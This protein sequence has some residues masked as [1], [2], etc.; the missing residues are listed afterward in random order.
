M[1]PNRY[2]YLY[3][4]FTV[5]F[6]VGTFFC[7]NPVL[8][9]ENT[10]PYTKIYQTTEN[11]FDVTIF[12]NEN[13]QHQPQN[14]GENFTPPEFT[15]KVYVAQNQARQGMSILVLEDVPDAFMPYDQAL[16]NLGHSRTLVTD[17]TAF[18]AELVGSPWD[19]V[20]VDSYN[21]GATTTVLDEL[22]YHASSGGFL[23]FSHWD[24][25]NYQTHP[26]LTTLGIGYISEF[27]VPMSFYG[28]DPSHP[29]FT[30]P[31]VISDFMWTHDQNDIDGQ[32]VDVL[33][34]ALHLAHFDGNPVSG[35]LVQNDLGN[36]F[37]N[38][39]Q[40]VNFQGDNNQNGQVDII[41]LAENQIEFFGGPPPDALTVTPSEFNEVLPVGGSSS[42]PGTIHNNTD[43]DIP[44]EITFTGLESEQTGRLLTSEEL[45]NT[46]IHPEIECTGS[47]PA[48]PLNNP[49]S[50]QAEPDNGFI[51]WET[52]TFYGFM[53]GP[54]G[55]RAVGFHADAD[56]SIN[57]L[58][59]SGDI[60]YENYDVIIYDSPDGYTVGTQLYGVTALSGGTGYG[61]NDIYFPGT[62]HFMAGNYYVINWRPTDQG[63]NDWGSLDYYHDDDLPFTIGQ[64][65]LTEGFEGYNAEDAANFLHPYFRMSSTGMPADWVSAYPT[66]GV[67][68][69][70]MDSFFDVFF[71]ASD[72]L[73]GI[74]QATMH[75]T[76][77]GFSPVDV[78]IELL[79]TEAGDFTVTPPFFEELLPVGGSSSQEGTVHNLS[80]SDIPV[81][82]TFTGLESEGAGRLLSWDELTQTIIHPDIECSGNTDLPAPNNPQTNDEEPDETFIYW[83]TPTFYGFMGGP[84]GGR[85]VGFHADADFPI[86]SLGISGD[87]TY[88]NYD[89]IIYDSP[90]G[91][92]VGT[93]LYGV[94]ALSGGSGYGWNDI[95]FPGTFHFMAGN[96]YV[97]NWR[98]TDQ[99]YN[100]WG[101]LDY[102]HDDD[103]PFT[104]GQA[105]LIEG[106]EGYNADDAA[107]YL[108]PY[109]RMSSTGMP[110]DW[111][112]AYPTSG[113]VPAGQDW[114]FDVFF[115]ATDLMPGTYNATMHVSSAAR[116]VVDVPI[117]LVVTDEGG[118]TVSPEFFDETLPM[119]G[120]S[121]HPMTIT[122]NSLVD[123][124]YNIWVDA[125]MMSKL[126]TQDELKKVIQE[127]KGVCTGKEQTNPIA[128]KPA[129]GPETPD[130]VYTYWQTPV[131]WGYLDGAGSGRAI[132]FHA[133]Q[134]FSINSLGIS[135]DITPENYDVIIYDSPDGHTAGTELFGVTA[136]SGGLGYAWND[137]IFPAPFDFIGG[138]YYVISWRPSD[139]GYNDWGWIDYYDDSGL[140]YTIE[141]ATLVEGFEGFNA[142]NADNYLHP[143]F[144][145][146]GSASPDF[147]LTV[148]PLT[149]V[150]GPGLSDVVDVHFDAHGLMPGIYNADINVSDNGGDPSAYDIFYDDG[151]FENAWAWYDPGNQSA[152]RM[153]PAGYPC[154][155]LGASI[156][157]YDG[158]WPDGNIYQP[159]DII[160]FD[161]DGPDG[162]PGT[163]LGRVNVPSPTTGWNDVDLSG[164]GIVVPGGDFYIGH[165]QLTTYP[166]CMPIAIDETSP[167]FRSYSRW[168]TGGEGWMLSD[169]NDHM[170]RAHVSGPMG[171][172]TL[173]SSGPVDV[174]NTENRN[175]QSVSINEPQALPELIIP[176][177][178]DYMPSNALAVVT[179]P[180]T[181]EVIDDGPVAP[182][183]LQAILDPATGQVDL[184]WS[185]GLGDGF[186]EDFEDGIAQNWIFQDGR[187]T[188]DQGA[189]QLNGLG[190]DSWGT[191]YYNQ[192]FTDFS[193]EFEATRW[194][195][196]CS[197]YTTMGAFIRSDGFMGYSGIENG[198]MINITQSGSYSAWL[199]QNGSETAMISWLS[200]PY[201]NT[202]LGASN[203]VT[204]DAYG[205]TFDIYINGSYVNTFV[206]ATFPSG[207]PGLI[208]YDAYGCVN[209]VSW[210][211][212]TL[213]TTGPTHE[214]TDTER[215]TQSNQIRT[216]NG[217]FS[218]ISVENSDVP[219]IGLIYPIEA[220]A[221]LNFNVYRDDVLI[222]TPTETFYTDFLP[223]YGLYIYEVTAQ[224]EQEE[225]AAAGPVEVLWE[226]ILYPLIDVEPESFTKTLPVGG[227]ASDILTI[228]NLGD[229]NLDFNIG[230]ESPAAS[231][232]RTQSSQ[233]N[234]NQ[235]IAS[236][237]P[238]KEDRVIVK[239]KNGLQESEM[240]SAAQMVNVSNIKNFK[241][242]GAQLW[243]LSDI[244]VADAINLLKNDPRIV[245]I[246]P[247]YQVSII[248]TPNDPMYT[249]L[250]GMHNIG[251]TGGTPDA[252]I[253]APEAW[254]T[255]TGNGVIIGVIDSGVDYNHPD[256]TNNMWTN[257]GEIPGNGIDDDGNGYV[258][259]IH[260]YDF[261]NGDGDPWDDNDHGTHCSG[262][263]AGEGNNGIGVAGVCWTAQIMALKFLD[264][265][266]SGWTSDAVYAIEYA[267]ANGAHLTNNSWGGGGYSSALYDAIDAA[268]GAGQLFCAASGNDG[269]N[270]DYSPHYPSSY[271]L[272]N[273]ISV[274]A[275]DHNDGLAGF[276]NYGSTSV[277]IGAPG[278]SIL[279]T[280]PGNTYQYFNGTSMATPHVAGAAALILSAN[281][282]LTD[283]EVKQLLFDG[284]DPIPSLTGMCQ[285]GARLN[286]NNS[287]NNVSSW[288]SVDT[289]SGSVMPG[290][291]Q[292]IGV[293]FDATGLALGVYNANIVIYNNDPLS[294]VVIVPAQL[295]VEGGL[296]PYLTVSPG[297]HFQTLEPDQSAT[298]VMNIGNTGDSP[299]SFNL[300]VNDAALQ[301]IIRQRHEANL[302]PNVALIVPAETGTS[303][304]I[305]GGAAYAGMDPGPN[306][307]ESSGWTPYAD[308]L[309]VRAQHGWV[310]HPNGNIYTF[311]GYQ[312]Q[313]L[314][315][316]DPVTNTYSYGADMPSYDRGFA[317]A[318][319]NNGHIYYFDAIGG[320]SHRYDPVGN[321]WY[322][323]PNPPYADVWEAEAARGHD[324]RIYLIGGEGTDS[325]DPLNAVQIYD[326]GT[327]TWSFG[328]PMPT[329]RYGHSVVTDPAGFIHAIGGRTNDFDAP[330]GVHEIY[331]PLTD[332]WS[333]G[334]PMLTPR[335]QFGACLGTDGQI[336]TVGGKV[337][338]LNHEGPFLN[339]VEIYHPGT[340]SWIPGSDYPIFVGELGAAT[341]TNTVFGSGGTDGTEV[342][343]VYGLSSGSSWLSVHPTSGIVDPGSSVNVDVM[344]NSTGLSDGIYNGLI[345][346][347]HNA[348]NEPSPFP[349]PAQLTVTSSDLPDIYVHPTIIDFGQVY[350]GSSSSDQFTVENTGPG[351]LVVSN[352]TSS[353]PEFS[354]DYNSFSVPPGGSQTVTATFS[355][356]SI[357]YFV[358]SLS[359]YSN[360]PDEPVV[361]VSVSGESY[362]VVPPT[363]LTVTLQDDLGNVNLSWD[364]DA[365]SAEE[366]GLAFQFYIIYRDGIFLDMS[367]VNSFTE[368]LPD[369]G[370]YEYYV[371]AMYDEG[372]SEPSNT[373][374]VNFTPGS[375]FVP[376]WSGNPYNAM[377]VF[378]LA[379]A[380]DDVPMTAGMEIG[381]FD[382]DEFDNEYCVGV[383]VLDDVIASEDFLPIQ[384]SQ[385][386]ADPADPPN[387]FIEG[388][389]IIYRLWDGVDE[390]TNVVS[391]YE[392]GYND[393]FEPLATTAVS[394]NAL[395]TR[396]Q[397]I[398]LITGWNIMS[399]NVIPDDINMMNIV[400][401]LIDLGVLVKVQD[402]TGNVIQYLPF[403]GS[404]YNGIGDMANT[405]G[406]QIKVN[407]D[408]SLT[409][410]GTPVTLPFDIPLITGW[411]IS[412]YPAFNPQDAM[413]AVQSLIDAG[414]L[415]K[416]Q[417]ETGNV[418]QYLPFLGSWYNGIG[419]FTEDEGY[420]IKVN[421][422]GTLTIAEGPAAMAS[423][424]MQTK[425]TTGHFN[426]AH[427][428]NPYQAMN[429]FVK[430]INLTGIDLDIGDEVAVYDVT[431]ANEPVCVGSTIINGSVNNQNPLIIIASADDPLSEIQDGFIQNH[432]IMFR[433]YDISSDTEY[434]QV[435]AEF[436]L[437][438]THTFTEL[439]TSIADL[440]ILATGID[441]YGKPG[442]TIVP[443][444]F[445]ESTVIYYHVNH[446][447]RVKMELYNVLGQKIAD[448]L[449]ET[450][451][452]GV[453]TLILHSDSYGPGTYY[454]RFSSGTFETT[455][456]LV[457]IK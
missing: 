326:P 417:D 195:S 200:S 58:G 127:N 55:G 185:Y 119:E 454:L 310:A 209:H 100:D 406:Y 82:I 350:V 270:T 210:D 365:A 401:Q 308:M 116:S 279:S 447:E 215:N 233:N 51:Y 101:S 420:Q 330:L 264:Y 294:P 153:T 432:E 370:V 213:S 205:S 179:V 255:T 61:W 452:P 164:L 129:L 92:T 20:I 316:F 297:E 21:Y 362:E 60:T 332:S 143:Y 309:E 430:N 194:Q 52:P 117:E 218:D 433:Y 14:S 103:L 17:W 238:Y 217:M 364:H 349:V 367:P 66:S 450:A 325:T 88:E 161:D 208:T 189:L 109:F 219:A 198:Y 387:G 211:Y 344:F 331:D 376:V 166:D 369:Y 201:I 405:E 408:A 228:S 426:T 411:N 91:H 43:G 128:D 398:D 256:L 252:D 151:G 76:P 267:I 18:E 102:Y 319:D 328:N 265:S 180:A 59:I 150:I 357:G 300:A 273:I 428:G 140:P 46:V 137:I 346:I 190:D 425:N 72:L 359:I 424:K 41:D 89:V 434:D 453:R 192:S 284:A 227:S 204:I 388:H 16:G 290:Y 199:V 158:T 84:G 343:N 448:L 358:G 81:D 372:E 118:F 296:F 203:I 336:Y 54:G 67:V 105:T 27:T 324:G 351:T 275:T 306:N 186:I 126:M 236:S 120:N 80:D 34:G 108:H 232:M 174:Q 418:I 138:N 427:Q 339:T 62:F 104:I 181:L 224:Y 63:Y 134:S 356:G 182:Y 263:I 97:I 49:Q 348:P 323:I 22:N 347:S 242:I 404:W 172:L 272:D 176:G 13:Q 30:I 257:P 230:I 234:Y 173:N 244:S 313:H 3:T 73:P 277:D 122:N 288:L 130:D 32:I 377:N 299:L 69:A 159:Y 371:T 333:G 403:L 394:L 250:W 115:D 107:N 221:F 295:T 44:F 407:S 412:S 24:V 99:G 389:T 167:D 57:S 139:G 155:V 245:Y 28:I 142:E 366:N 302:L 87:I 11:G 361:G 352:I 36:T 341:S 321:S 168:I 113:V 141:G 393:Y 423:A 421:S 298:Q 5:F 278:V 239:F 75:V 249:D 9:Q 39:F 90:D 301:S 317:T 216:G 65:T 395:T 381:V 96:Y 383:G 77:Y 442:I 378:I 355:P 397:I 375:H 183:D 162:M 305:A 315:I 392:I 337:N 441:Q 157:N 429:I 345:D 214:L 7:L 360:D 187:F 384:V 373:A 251:Q 163:E 382:V 184:S 165:E 112:S 274:A 202:G 318:I 71:D 354:V 385:N 281:P 188:V 196:D 268:H 379:A 70:G 1:K 419:N 37:F 237:V 445:Q 191:A 94:T 45:N 334:A 440:S 438:Y 243:T 114:F 368:M 261:V 287:I 145:I 106:F 25:Y 123:L 304:L 86:N 124:N 56:F 253:D 431:E 79:V 136:P 444:P 78:P 98:P 207:Y 4:L 85:A 311:G 149:G 110:M 53:G 10:T 240:A 156:H 132:G 154:N 125:I 235:D 133:D 292:D 241:Y 148:D 291:F 436:D 402:E 170:V 446:T 131:F 435:N 322:S 286:I 396:T 246:E 15:K 226:L 443:N 222:G 206:D 269:M 400:Q 262:T 409:L 31:N 285:T 437:E 220:E 247:D 33:P 410:L 380:I 303:G 19:L 283:L 47:S 83:E 2:Q 223:Q 68:P 40:P 48:S 312:T 327:D 260:G 280:T 374:S 178:P 282:G 390:Y 416:V 266:G 320:S 307:M 271:N 338:Y 342:N 414:I 169:Y 258:D 415:V 231:S 449:E 38:A 289:H 146:S 8:A 160:V 314:D 35:A 413:D 197:Y 29:V 439:G 353:E 135:G 386:D 144:R 111:V 152:V 23:I 171:P 93:Q 329:A 193:F 42:Q 455:K 340:D 254:N 259:D 212:A 225:S 95:Y 422:D 147:W 456:R 175:A 121:T 399:F 229:A 248:N 64:A 74:Y 26:F 391:T 363:N 451:T 276:S 12:I 335:N 293:F 6:F 457:M 177:N 50:P